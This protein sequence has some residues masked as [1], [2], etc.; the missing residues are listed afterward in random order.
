MRLDYKVTG[1]ADINA[2]LRDVGPREGRNLMRATVYD[3]AKQLAT[4]ASDRVPKDS[5]DLAAGIKA[6]RERSPRDRADATVRAAPFYWRFLE[7]GDGPDGVEHAFFLGS[8]QEMR[9][10]MDRVYLEAFAKKLAARMAR[11][12]KRSGK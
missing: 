9:P 10:Q 2:V 11:E 3:I 5:G 6:R 12:R 4:G 8:L 1:I 7:Y